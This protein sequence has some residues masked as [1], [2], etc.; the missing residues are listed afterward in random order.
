MSKY[1]TI[2]TEDQSP[3]LVLTNTLQISEAM[4]ST[5]GAF[6]ESIYIYGQAI[7]AA[8]EKKWPLNVLSLGLGLG[9]NE[10]LT[11]AYYL[12]SQESSLNLLSFESNSELID[13]FE[14]WILNKPDKFLLYPAYEQILQLTS[15]RLSIDAHDIKERLAQGLSSG[16]IKLSMAL[17]ANTSF[18]LQYNVILFDAFSEKM[19]ADL[20]NENF[21]TDFLEKA[22]SPKCI[23][24]TYA[25]KGALSRSLK[26][27]GFVLE[28]KPGFKGKRQSTFAVRDPLI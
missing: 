22:C 25:A 14:S 15:D 8:L 5:R 4:H 3:S 7:E 17:D 19:N 24:S 28:Q 2:T 12:K 1:Q 21:L 13:S 18:Q 6:S 11:I 26:K 23:F 10:I 27:A 9:Y 16:A 20:W